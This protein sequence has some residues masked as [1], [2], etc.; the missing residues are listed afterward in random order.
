MKYS[1]LFGLAFIWCIF[2]CG[3]KSSHLNSKNQQNLEHYYLGQ[4]VD[5][6]IDQVNYTKNNDRSGAKQKRME[7]HKHWKAYLQYRNHG[8]LADGLWYSE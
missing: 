2:G 7:A 1:I 3:C 4:Y 5:S 6:V 8:Q